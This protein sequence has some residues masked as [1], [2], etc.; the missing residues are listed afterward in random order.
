MLFEIEA[1][2]PQTI[3]PNGMDIRLEQ[4]FSGISESNKLKLLKDNA[5][6]CFTNLDGEFVWVGQSFGALLGYD[7]DELLSKNIR[8]LQPSIVGEKPGHDWWN[9]I[10]KNKQW[11]GS[12][13]FFKKD[14]GRQSLICTMSLIKDETNKQ[15]HFFWLIKVN[16]QFVNFQ[17]YIEN[18]VSYKW[19]F[20]N[21][22]IPKSLYSLTTFQFVDVNTSWETFTEYKKDYALEQRPE[23]LK[24]YKNINFNFMIDFQSMRISSYNIDNGILLTKSNKKKYVVINYEKIDINGEAFLSGTITDVSAK[25]EY[26]KKLKNISKR[27]VQKKDAILKLTGLVGSDLNHIFEEITMLTAKIMKIE[28]VS[29]WKFSGTDHE[30]ICKNDYNLKEGEDSKYTQFKVHYC[31]NYSDYL[32]KNKT[33][34]VDDVYKDKRTKGFAEEYLKP[35]GIT[36]T[37][38]VLVQGNYGHYGV[39]CIEHT[40][41]IKH[42][43]IEDEEFATSIANIISLAIVSEERNLA[44]VKLIK[45]NEKL[46]TVNSELKKLKKE[47]EE[48]N[49]YLREEIGLVFNYE[50]MVYGSESFSKVL[51]DVE[52]VAATNA[53]VLLL[54]ESGTGKELLARAIHNISPRKNKPLIKV[55]CAAI[56][57]ELIESELFGH[58]KGSFTGAIQDKL[59]KFQLAD[60]GTLFLDEI[61][62]LP[63]EMQPKLLRAIQE[64]EIEQIGSTKTQKV[65]IRII[66]A[67]NR[68]LQKEIKEKNFREDLYFRINVFPITIPPLRERIEDI[69]ILIE[70]FVNKFSKLYNKNI[71]YISEGTKRDLQSYPWPGNIRELENLIERAIILSNDEKL[72][73]PNFKTSTKESLISSTGLSLEDVQRIHIKKILKECKWKIEGPE[74]AAQLLQINPSTLRDRMKKLHI[75]KSQ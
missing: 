8:L 11:K 67:T 71:K 58:K 63:M 43:T 68:D 6:I 55:N 51:T 25:V 28:R 46:L 65:D 36:S 21:S 32:F 7:E 40:G 72:V 57:R 30:L 60:G 38:D 22:P 56:P 66:A 14:G 75:A 45:N 41:P 4:I 17:D 37:L 59:G 12:V 34:I 74:G 23:D 69:P 13:N 9:I 52:R 15:S 50:E 31:S 47:L 24:L 49:S 1:K 61:G 2:F 18:D 62:E 26:Q 27:S 44:E 19:F 33:L 3:N 42:W 73:I 54:G 35:F 48:E 5:I 29:I 20:K 64:S 70:H 10:T 53:T 39:F 16:Q